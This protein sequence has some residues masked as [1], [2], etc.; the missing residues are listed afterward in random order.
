MLK[1][2]ES[3]GISNPNPQHLWYVPIFV[4]THWTIWT[5]GS[6][7]NLILNKYMFLDPQL[8]TYHSKVFKSL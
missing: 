2:L 5:V 4:G 7:V 1:L 3:Y 8:T 6:L